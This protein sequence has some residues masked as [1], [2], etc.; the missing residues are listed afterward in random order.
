MN[1]KTLS[2]CLALA[3]VF[4]IA[5]LA[6]EYLGAAYPLWTGKEIR[7]KTIPLDPRSLFMGNYAR[8]KYDI[9]TVDMQDWG[10]KVEP[11]DGEFVYVRLKPGADGLYSFDGVGPEKPESG[12]FIRGRFKDLRSNPLKPEVHYG[13]EAYFA[14]EKKAQILEREMWQG[15]IAVVMVAGNGKAALKDVHLAKEN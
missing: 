12:P 2:A 13:I 5:V 15:G 1:R 14:P 6:G 7:L 4:Q 8:L 10:G 11:R 3:V 9:S